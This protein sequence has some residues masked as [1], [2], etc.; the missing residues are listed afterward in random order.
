MNFEPWKPFR[1]VCHFNHKNI[2]E[3]LKVSLAAELDIDIKEI[4][5]RVNDE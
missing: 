2:N 3:E 4:I 5:K 1:V